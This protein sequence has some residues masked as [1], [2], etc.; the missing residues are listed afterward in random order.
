MSSY[1]LPIDALHKIKQGNRH[2][3][4]VKDSID[5]GVPLANMLRSLN[6]FPLI[7]GKGVVLPG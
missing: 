5:L 6:N 1:G 7:K 4:L 3:I 2:S